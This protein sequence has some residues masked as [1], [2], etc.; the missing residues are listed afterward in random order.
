MTTQKAAEVL[1]HF[2]AWRRCLD[3][4]VR[5]DFSPFTIGLAIDMAVAALSLPQQ[6]PEEVTLQYLREQTAKIRALTGYPGNI[7][8]NVHSGSC[9]SCGTLSVRADCWGVSET[10]CGGGKIG[11]VVDSLVMRVDRALKFKIELSARAEMRP[12]HSAPPIAISAARTKQ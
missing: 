10:D 9:A 5:Y 7:S 6:T 8:I 3:G 4:D 1:C 2:N 11:C 12:K